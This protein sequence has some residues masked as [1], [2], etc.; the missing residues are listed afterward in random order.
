MLT[1]ISYLKKSSEEIIFKSL[2]TIILK[3][4]LYGL[5]PLQPTRQPSGVLYNLDNCV[6]KIYTVFHFVSRF[7]PFGYFSFGDFIGRKKSS[8]HFIG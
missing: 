7:F 6:V 1:H 4:I 5:M 8:R 2:Q 3:I